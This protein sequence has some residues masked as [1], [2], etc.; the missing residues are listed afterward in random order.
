MELLS[1][2]QLMELFSF[3]IYIEVIKKKSQTPQARLESLIKFSLVVEEE[4]Q[5]VRAAVC[6]PCSFCSCKNNQ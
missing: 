2:I 5:N 6:P 1:F 3:F 4:M